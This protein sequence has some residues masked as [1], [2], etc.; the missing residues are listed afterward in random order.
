MSQ[1]GPRFTEAECR[2]YAQIAS[3]DG[4]LAREIAKRLS[5]PKKEINR[6]L[7]GSALMRELCYQDQAY[8]WHS[9]VQQTFPH[10]GLYEFCAW[11]GTGRELTEEPEDIWLNRMQEGCQRIGRN[12]N[13][14]RGLLHSFR[15]CRAT[16]LQL[17]ADLKEMIN[18]SVL[19]WELAFE[20]RMN[21]ARYIRIYADVLLIA[22][23]H[24][25]SLEFKMKGAPVEEELRQAVKY[26]PSLELILGQA[27]QVIPVLVLTAA[28]DLFEA[29]PVPGTDAEVWVCS[30]DMLFNVMNEYM[31]FLK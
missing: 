24:A 15:D 19:D 11:Y 9:V 8:R 2:I 21:R 30:G 20:V 18:S 7:S 14:T 27:S 3:H 5:I 4:I 26:A 1:Y 22:G 31:D 6:F 12:L 13:D 10:A 28:S 25:F 29:L 17:F 16:M 23:Q